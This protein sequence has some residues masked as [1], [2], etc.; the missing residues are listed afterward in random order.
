LRPG[1]RPIHTLAPVIVE[2]AEGVVALSTPGADGQ[3]QTLLQV[4]LGWAIAG[5]ELPEA[6]AVPR[7][8]SEDGRLLVEAGH[9]ARDDLIARGHDVV[10]TPA[11]DM[12][13]GA[14]TAAGHWQGA[15]FALADWRRTT[16]AGVA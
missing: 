5:K 1:K 9:L 6:V 8:R 3:V 16:W 11:G 4:I 15:P 13:F 14:V 7:W 2:R 10:D 12:R